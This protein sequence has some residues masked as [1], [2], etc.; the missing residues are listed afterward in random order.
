MNKIKIEKNLLGD[1]FEISV[2]ARGIKKRCRRTENHYFTIG[3]I[4]YNE[5]YTTKDLEQYLDIAAHV[6][7]TKMRI[8]Q[9][10]ELIFT[11]FK[12]KSENGFINSTTELFDSRNKSLPLKG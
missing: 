6:L 12:R 7:L 9:K 4:P 11:K 2:M 8:T 10:A 5:G 3:D 1:I